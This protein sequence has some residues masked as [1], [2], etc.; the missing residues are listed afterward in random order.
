MKEGSNFKV[1]ART[2]FQLG[3]EA[4]ESEISAVSELV[5]NAYDADSTKCSVFFESIDNEQAEKIIIQDDGNGMSYE[6]VEKNWLRIGTNNKRKEKNSPKFGRPMLGEKGIG[7]LALN[8]LGNLVEIYTKTEEDKLV[9]FKIDF[10]EFMEEKELETIPIHLQ[11][12][13]NKSEYSDLKGTKMIISKL[14]DKWDKPKIL[15]FKKEMEAL[16]IPFSEYKID[17]QNN[18]FK[19]KE[20]QLEENDF[21]IIIDYFFELSEVEKK[22]FEEMNNL[23]EYS[24]FR[25]KAKVNTQT[26]IINYT[27]SFNPYSEMDRLDSRIVLNDNHKIIVTTNKKPE[28]YDVKKVDIGTIDIHFFAYDFSTD[29]VRR[30]PINNTRIFKGL[31]RDNGGVKVYRDGHRVY[32]YGEKGNDWLGV[33]SKRVNRPGRFVSNNVLI[34][35]VQ[36]NRET[37]HLL[38]E[39]TNREGF[40]EDEASLHFKKIIQEMLFHYSH[41]IEDDK[42]RIKK[43]YSKARNSLRE[44]EIYNDVY[45]KIEE[46]PRVSTNVKDELKEGLFLYKQQLE[47]IKEILINTSTNAMDYL[48][49]FHDLEKRLE[50]FSEEMNQSLLNDEQIAKFKSIVEMV[51][52]HNS[53]LR[54]KS[55]KTIEINDLIESIIYEKRYSFLRSNVKAELYLDETKDK[56]IKCRRSDVIRIFENIFSNSL[57]WLQLI[58]GERKI[59]IRTA[60]TSSNRLKVIIDDNGP[61]FSG[62]IEFLKEPFKTTKANGTGIG[63]GLFIIDELISNSN[64]YIELD[65]ESMFGTG[66]SVKL[67]FKEDGV[68][69]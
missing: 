21:K 16:Q 58:E 66:A 33:D 57:Y 64:G 5:K 34:G 28:E 51:A 67:F 32:N 54:E 22:K 6:Q 38:V 24:I 29:V 42:T 25:M 55:E 10:E 17:E 7:R 18:I 9:Y 69:N 15:K 26:G 48:S 39:K 47:R 59:G 52:N 65:N 4:I 1:D 68:L 50:E 20:K 3:R 40:I 45:E 41:L 63:L 46:L 23:L 30:S 13:N 11:E 37:S 36:L 44:D 12:I 61:G 56:K 35:N 19:Q 8:R 60:V 27:Y 14:L 43:A 49:I 53:L 31:V 62:D 2:I